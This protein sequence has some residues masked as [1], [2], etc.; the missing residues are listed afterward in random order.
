MNNKKAIFP[1]LQDMFSGETGKLILSKDWSGNS[2]G[3]IR[4]W[5]ESLVVF[6][7]LVS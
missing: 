6:C 7:S 4:N 1:G 5:P 3:E 2:I